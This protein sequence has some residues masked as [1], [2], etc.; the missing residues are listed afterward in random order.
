MSET[1]RHTLLG[2]FSSTSPSAL[3]EGNMLGTQRIAPAWMQSNQN[4]QHRMDQNSTEDRSAVLQ[5]RF[6][7]LADRQSDAMVGIQPPTSHDENQRQLQFQS[8][9]R[10]TTPFQRDPFRPDAAA[11]STSHQ[12]SGLEAAHSA[13][14]RT[15]PDSSTISRLSGLEAA[16][17]AADRIH[18]DY[19]STTIV[20]ETDAAK[21][22]NTLKPILKT[23]AHALRSAA[24]VRSFAANVFGALPQVRRLVH[25]ATTPSVRFDASTN[26]VQLQSG[27]Q[28]QDRLPVTVSCA[29]AQP[30]AQ[31]PGIGISCPGRSH[32]VIVAASHADESAPTCVNEPAAAPTT[33]S[34]SWHV[35]AVAAVPAAATTSVVPSESVADS[36]DDRIRASA[37]YRKAKYQ[38]RPPGSILAS[39]ASGTSTPIAIE[40]ILAPFDGT[41]IRKYP[42]FRDGFLSI[43]ENVPHLQPHHKLQYLS[44]CLRGDARQ[45]VS[46]PL[47]LM[48]DDYYWTIIELLEERYGNEVKLKQ[49]LAQDLLQLHSPE[50][51]VESLIGFHTKATSIVGRLKY[52]G[53]DV[54]DDAYYDRLMSRVP[55]PLRLK[56]IQ[57]Y[58]CRGKRSV[59]SVLAGIRQY[60]NDLKE[61]EQVTFEDIEVLDGSPLIC[62]PEP[63]DSDRSPTP[64]EDGREDSTSESDGNSS[65]EH[66]APTATAAPAVEDE[67]LTERRTCPLCG[68]LHLAANCFMYPT[69]QQRLRRVLKLKICLL[70]LREGHPAS[71]CPRRTKKSCKTCGHGQHHRV[72]CKDG[73]DSSRRKPLRPGQVRAIYGS[74]RDAGSSNPRRYS[75]KKSVRRDVTS[76]VTIATK[77]C[78]PGTQ[79]RSEQ[80]SSNP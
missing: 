13:A 61:V 64:S 73:G 43:V 45:L 76:R 5:Q 7:H 70:C 66:S 23:R 36:E 59:R 44:L 60:I 54:E 30:T 62:R 48:S 19:S 42:E 11:A 6:T 65:D 3:I 68:L 49:L 1:S 50:D 18:P 35:P 14:D 74:S 77:M 17:S 51:N 72:L 27:T 22:L 28:D 32:A 16:H 55:A 4:T 10:I 57:S 24:A 79:S 31:D 9:H 15:H 52:L 80:G 8:T 33:P 12:L 78:P 63:V 75:R 39:T 20:T 71:M 34:N 58:G 53:R 46:E 29:A 69:I 56:L 21:R 40:M 25:G 41:D 2:S 37:F 26:A 47:L 67:R 38:R